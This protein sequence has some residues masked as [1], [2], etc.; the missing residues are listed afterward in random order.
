MTHIEHATDNASV[1]A[2]HSYCWLRHVGL[3]NMDSE[4]NKG[5]RCLVNKENK[6]REYY[7]KKNENVCWWCTIKSCKV[8]VET[9]NG[10]VSKTSD[11]TLT[12]T[13]K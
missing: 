9:E 6:Y 3:S 13:M 2:V 4:N 7:R 5:Q 11:Y 8:R 12:W 1:W 10:I